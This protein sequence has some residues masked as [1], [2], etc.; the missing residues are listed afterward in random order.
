MEKFSG[1]AVVKARP[2]RTQTIPKATMGRKQGFDFLERPGH[3]VENSTTTE[4]VCAGIQKNHHCSLGIFLS[5]HAQAMLILP[6]QGKRLQLQSSLTW[7][8]KN[9]PFIAL[10]SIPLLLN[11][12]VP[13]AQLHRFALCTYLC[14]LGAVL[15]RQMLLCYKQQ[16]PHT[17]DLPEDFWMCIFERLQSVAFRN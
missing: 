16:M 3:T 11:I 5:D 1:G 14:R 17:T 6:K 8:T 9:N 13:L 4:M 2:L 10:N 12:Y 7:P 15:S